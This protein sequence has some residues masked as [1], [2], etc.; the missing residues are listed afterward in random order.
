MNRPTCEEIA[1]SQSLWNEYADPSGIGGF[2]EMT[3]QERLD[4]LHELWPQD[5]TCKTDQ[6]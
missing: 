3:Y 2:D 6:E 4:M 1:K 5:C